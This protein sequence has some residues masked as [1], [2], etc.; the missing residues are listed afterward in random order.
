MNEEIQFIECDKESEIFIKNEEEKKTYQYDENFLVFFVA[1]LVHAIIYAICVY[2]NPSGLAYGAFVVSGM[3]Y[4]LF[5]LKKMELRIKKG[6][7]FYIVAII[8]L[9]VATFCTDDSSII[10]M[11]KVGIFCLTVIFVM[12]NMFNTEKW[13]FGKY[14]SSLIVTMIMSVSE[15]GE[16]FENVYE[17]FKNKRNKINTKYYYGLLGCIIAVPIV[18][19]MIILLSSADAVFKEWTARVVNNINIKDIIGITFF[20]IFMFV[21]SY[22][23]MSYLGK[24]EL[25]DKVEDT[26]RWEPMM[27][28]PVITILTVVYIIFSGIQIA[29]LFVGEFNLPEGYTYAEYAREGFFQ[30]L[31]VSIINLVIV[32]ACVGYTKTSKAVKVILTVMSLCTFIMIASSAVRMVT[33]IQFYYL[34]FLRIFV[35]WSL[36]VLFFVFAGVII[37]IFKNTFPIFRYVVI[38]TTCLYICLSF[39]RPDYFI[40]KVNLSSTDGNESAFF[41]GDSFDDYKFLLELSADAAPVV[42]E[43]MENQGYEYEIGNVYINEE[44]LFFYN[45]DEFGENY[46][47]KIIE[48]TRGMGI[49]EFNVSRYVAKMIIKH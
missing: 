1:T 34:T 12:D 32:L 6:S 10:F 5:C 24:K 21:A 9:G 7:I 38:V 27:V 43:W 4:I 23:T 44:Y 20:F 48:K 16:Y 35:L 28:I 18:G 2:K 36:L 37:Y 26:K 33:Y 49:R 31:A 40:A 17:Y 41:L 11:N 14:F 47:S 22:C 39:S 25:D 46:M 29:Y 3:I 19:V 30:L 13:Q 45:P 15:I 42:A 8:I